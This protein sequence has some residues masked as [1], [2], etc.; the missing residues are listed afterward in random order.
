VHLLIV[1]DDQRLGRVLDR[2]FSADRHV[3]EVVTTGADALDVV[4]AGAG[5]DAII[6]DVGLPDHNGLEV[7]R[8]LRSQ[9]S[10]VPVLMLTARDG[11]PDRVAGLDAG[12]DDYMVKPFAYEELSARLR[13]LVRRGGST[14]ESVIRVGPIELDEATRR[15]AVEGV[16]LQLSQREF[17]LLEVLMRHPDHVLSRDQVLDHAWP[18]GVAVTPNSV[19]AY[20]SFVRRKLGPAGSRLQTVRGIGYRM[21]SV[22]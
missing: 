21:V 12:A 2:L 6:L 19:D 17:A 14:R 18:M 16:P 22:P 20:V 8:R 1:E 4:D 10:R 11:V 15:V 3:V 5:L 13:A 7:C 9:G